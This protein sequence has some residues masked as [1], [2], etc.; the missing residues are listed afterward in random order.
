MIFKMFCCLVVKKVIFSGCLLFYI[1][2][3]NGVNF[4]LV[5]TNKTRILSLIYG[6]NTTMTEKKRRESIYEYRPVTKET[7]AHE[8]LSKC[9]KNYEVISMKQPKS[10]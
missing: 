4:D 9:F 2:L 1:D 6:K 3:L 10:L 8:D 5:N 7:I